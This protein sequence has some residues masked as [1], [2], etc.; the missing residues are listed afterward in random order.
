M[1]NEQAL[2][3]CNRA[4][5]ATE[6][7]NMSD[8]VKSYFQQ[9]ALARFPAQFPSESATVDKLA[10][11]AFVEG[12]MFGSQFVERRRV[13]Q[14]DDAKLRDAFAMAALS[15]YEN[16]IE[17]HEGRREANERMARHCYEIA[18]ACMAER[19]K[20]LADG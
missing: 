10:R 19:A 15:D 5:T 13:E 9:E 6:G 17:A 16:V 12:A 4:L 8:P 7:L 2:E 3:L 1:T 14:A 11:E 20:G 18:D